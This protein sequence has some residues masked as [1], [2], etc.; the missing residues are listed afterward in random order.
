MVDWRAGLL[1]A[2]SISVPNYDELGQ[3]RR[4]T[5]VLSMVAVSSASHEIW[6]I[7]EY[8]GRLSPKAKFS[9]RAWSSLAQ[10]PLLIWFQRSCCC[11]Q[12][13]K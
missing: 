10:W 9:A 5:G 11:F 3:L 12:Q 8:T 13:Y 7:V 4:S 2:F 6:T 1:F